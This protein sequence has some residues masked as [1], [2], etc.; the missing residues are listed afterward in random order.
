MLFKR[1][2]KILFQGDSITD[3]NRDQINNDLN[4]FLGHGYVYLLAARLGMQYPESGWQFINRGIS[5]HRVTDLYARWRTDTLNLKPDVLS[6]LV[7]INGISSEVKRSDGVS[8]SRYRDIYRIMLEDTLTVLPNLTLILCSPFVL[9]VGERMENWEEY[10]SETD[11]R[12]AIVGELAKE[13]DAVHVPLQKSFDK[14][15]EQ[16]PAEYWLW[17]GVHPMP[18]GH[19]LIAQR[20]LLELEK[21]N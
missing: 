18:A 13:F 2:A 19:E 6:V 4:H 5:G 1:N 17:D 10:R 3:G 8:A 20:W 16:A 15:I 7:G 14:A 11:K 21:H 12:I 9:E